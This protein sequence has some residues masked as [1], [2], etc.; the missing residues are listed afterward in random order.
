[1]QETLVLNL[2]VVYEAPTVSRR[3]GLWDELR[4]VM[5]DIIVI[6]GDFNTIDV[7]QCRYTVTF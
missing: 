2:I 6:G 4:D 5:R 7:M 3:S 1:M